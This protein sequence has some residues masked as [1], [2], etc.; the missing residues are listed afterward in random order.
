MKLEFDLIAAAKKFPDRKAYC[1]GERFLTYR[2]LSD[3]AR[4]LAAELR[5]QGKG[6]VLLM[7][8]K[9][10]E[11]YTALV[12]CLEAERAYV[13]VEESLPDVR[14]E[15]IIKLSGCSSVLK[16]KDGKTVLEPFLPENEFL[17]TET[18]Y[19]IFTS[20]STGEPKGVPIS[21]SALNH[22]VRW[23]KEV[24]TLAEAP[25][26]A[27]FCPAR[28]SF[29]LSVAGIALALSF[30]QTYVDSESEVWADSVSVCRSLA[31]ESVTTVVATPTYV[32][33]LLLDPDFNGNKLS[34][35]SVFYFCGERL[36][37][38]LAEKLQKRFPLAKILNA[39]GPTEATSAVS[40]IEI[41]PKLLSEEILPVGLEKEAA[42]AITVEDG[43]I[44][45]CGD[46]V[47]GGYIGSENGAFSLRNGKTAYRT[48]D[49]GKIRDGKIYCYGRKDEQIKFKGYRIELFDI[50][51]NL[52]KIC[53]VTD[54]AVIAK[55]DQNSSV[56]RLKAFLVLENGVN[57]EAVRKELYNRLPSY[58]IPQEWMVLEKLPVNGNG[59]TD[60]KRLAE[61][62][63]NYETAL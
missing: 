36:E 12:A 61:K 33:G 39:Y 62:N 63:G 49:L 40:A 57:A 18:A 11:L 46:S 21:C 54:C 38:K 53:G 35:L 5:K 7:G 24:K 47:A 50:E 55:R 17:S 41:T 10:P 16:I 32:K 13:P 3:R 51:N 42:V 1:I 58:M 8:E 6:P 30:G 23:I 60:R 26:N 19:I 43:E 31:K 4:I 27:V 22:F 37:K 59:K 56:M 25:K 14:R 15:R 34:S 45:L 52:R 29:D 9:S 2:E 44:I 20:G 28:F 48:G